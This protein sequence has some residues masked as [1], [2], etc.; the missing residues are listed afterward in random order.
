MTLPSIVPGPNRDVALVSSSGFS[1]QAFSIG[2]SFC[3][4]SEAEGQRRAGR[5][6]KAQLLDCN[7]LAVERRSREPRLSD[8][9]S[10]GRALGNPATPAYGAPCESVNDAC[11]VYGSLAIIYLTY[12][13]A[14][15]KMTTW[16]NG[17]SASTAR[18]RLTGWRTA[19][20]PGGPIQTQRQLQK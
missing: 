3:F 2:T 8:R 16:P 14:R 7:G 13:T 12:L 9:N 20:F 19:S 18:A 10:C 17:P 5:V 11:R 4:R 6:R 1:R 15:A